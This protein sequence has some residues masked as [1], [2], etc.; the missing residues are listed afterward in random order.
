M[1]LL[2]NTSGFTLVELVLSMTIFAVM[3]TAIISIYIQTTALS[4]RLKSSRY[5]S[6]TA[7]EITERIS[8]DVREYGM[9]GSTLL[10]AYVPW[11]N[12]TYSDGSEIL[13]IWDGTKKYVYGI[14]ELV[15][16]NWTVNPCDAPRKND[17]REHCWLYEI[18]GSSA[19]SYQDAFNLVDSF[20]PEES[21]KRVKIRDLR[22]FISWDGV[23]TERKVTLV[24][25]LTLMPRIGVPNLSVENSTLSVQTT[26]TARSFQKN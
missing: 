25:T 7:R 2:K 17:P 19:Q 10:S 1:K 3:T 26:I 14:K 22:F 5:L 6:E 11:N 18:I 8:E 15:W 21:K 20:I 23:K 12:P 4:Y 9:T 13:W 24:F 16:V